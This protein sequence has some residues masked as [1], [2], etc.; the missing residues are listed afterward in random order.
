MSAEGRVA[1]GLVN[2]ALGL[3]ATLLWV[4]GLWML[5][6]GTIL[7]ADEHV[8]RWNGLVLIATGFGCLLVG[9]WRIRRARRRDEQGGE[10]R[11]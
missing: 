7:G 10:V 9:G 6:T 8:P 5:A 3:G 4:L 11:G 1:D 2:R